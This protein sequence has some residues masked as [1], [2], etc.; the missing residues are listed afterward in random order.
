MHK[1]TNAQMPSGKNPFVTISMHYGKY[2]PPYL[3][4]WPKWQP[5]A[6]VFMPF[7]AFNFSIVAKKYLELSPNSYLTKRPTISNKE[8][9]LHI[10]TAMPRST[11]PS[12]LYE[13]VQ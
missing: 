1:I 7:G 10:F 2:V 12:T 11:Q 5:A 8:H 3:K 6:F 4:T 13:I 9:G